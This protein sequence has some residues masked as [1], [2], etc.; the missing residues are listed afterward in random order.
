MVHQLNPRDARPVQHRILFVIT[1]AFQ[2]GGGIAAVNRLVIHAVHTRYPHAQMD[3][4]ALHETNPSVDERYVAATRISCKGF[5]GKKVS[6]VASAWRRLLS[7]SY[8]LVIFDLANLAIIF[9]PL[10]KLGLVKYVVWLF[11]IDVFPPNPSW[12]GKIGLRYAWRRLAISSFTR[13]Q[14]LKQ[15]PNLDVRVV[16][17]ALDPTLSLPPFGHD[18]EEHG[19][20][21]QM[22]SVGGRSDVLH[23]RVILHVGRMAAS[24]RY[25]GQDVLIEAMPLILARFPDAQLV[26]VGKGDDM[27][28][29]LALARRQP[30]WVQNRIFM[31]GYVSQDTLDRLYATCCLFAMPSRGEGFG[32]VYLEAMRWGKPCLGSRVD[33]A[34]YVIRDGETGIL[35]DDPTSI[36][37]IAEK[38]IWLF[39]NPQMAQ[40]MGQ[41]GRERVSSHYLFHHFY[42]RFW[43]AL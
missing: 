36:E 1:G 40:A 41:A 3:V 16:E 42:R 15:F 30:S 43:D 19:A 6:F 34:Q 7:R 31:P 2:L 27:P 22:V 35:V 18:A 9:V 10:A 23:S 11:G 17:L 24:E 39:E 37:E 13:D 29:L 38:I 33:A 32:L 8:D 21:I 28:R 12:K 20:G 14:L 26:L 4:L 5:A 25:K